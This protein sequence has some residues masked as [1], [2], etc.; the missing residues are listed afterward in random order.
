MSTSTYFT[1]KQGM[2]ETNWTNYFSLDPDGQSLLACITSI[3]KARE[4]ATPKGA[5]QQ[6]AAIFRV[7]SLSHHSTPVSISE[8]NVIETAGMSKVTQ[9]FQLISCIASTFN[10]S[11]I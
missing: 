7:S 4:W 6:I 10:L 8:N 1:V 5:A 11:L 2:R 3:I 9:Q